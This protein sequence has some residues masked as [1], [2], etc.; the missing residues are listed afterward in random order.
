[1]DSPGRRPGALEPCARRKGGQEESTD[2]GFNDHR[3]PGRPRSCAPRPATTPPKDVLISVPAKLGQDPPKTVAKAFSSIPRSFRRRAA[4]WGNIKE[5]GQEADVLAIQLAVN[6]QTPGARPRHRWTPASTTTEARNAGRRRE[7]ILTSANSNQI[8]ISAAGSQGLPQ[9]KETV[10]RTLVA[11]K[12][13]DLLIANGY[14]EESARLIE[15]AAKDSSGRIDTLPQGSVALVVGALDLAGEYRAKQIAIFEDKEYVVTISAKDD[16]GY[17]EAAEPLIPPGLLE[18]RRDGVRNARV[19]P[20]LTASIA[21]ACAAASGGG[22][23]RTIQLVSRLADLK[24]PLQADEAVRV[25]YEGDYRNKA[26]STGKVVYVGLRG[27]LLMVDCYAFEE[28]DGYFR[29]FDPNAVGKSERTPRARAR[30]QR[31]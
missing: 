29:C 11:E 4:T 12:I 1:M 25:L 6:S 20:S 23:S 19:S 2:Q 3:S 10:L 5:S 9:L 8:E 27:G 28:I 14:S 24:S 13:S 22:R 18:D 30:G 31:G 17:G 26:R 15:A 16:G 7:L 21:P